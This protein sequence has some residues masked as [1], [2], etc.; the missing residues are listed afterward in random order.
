[1]KFIGICGY[2]N[3]GKDF[4][5]SVLEEYYN[6]IRISLGDFLKEQCKSECIKKFGIDP[7]ACSREDKNKIRDFLVSYANS[8]RTISS[9]TYFTG[10]ADN[11]IRTLSKSY[12]TFIIPDIR[13]D[14]YPKDETNWLLTKPDSVLIHV[15]R[16]GVSAPN[17]VEKLNNPKVARKAHVNL[18]PPNFVDEKTKNKDFLDFLIS[19]GTINTINERLRISST[20]KK[21]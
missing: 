7:A 2:A 13:F 9:G 18:T 10:L 4:L 12:D 20:S 3:S 6:G 19:S 21:L 14:C 11:L 8:F 17:Y 5:C 1:M 15:K 16:E